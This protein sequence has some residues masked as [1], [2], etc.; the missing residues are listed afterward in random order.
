MKRRDFLQ[1]FSAAALLSTIPGCEFNAEERNE[2][3]G[4]ILG[5]N[6]QHGHLLRQAISQAVDS[7]IHQEVIIVGGGVSGLTA[8]HHLKKAGY[9]EFSLL[10]FHNEAGGNA[11][12]GKNATSTFPWGAHYLPIP[13]T[14]QPELIQFLEETGVITHWEDQLPYFNDDY[15]CFE[16]EE[17]LFIK[18][19]WQDGLIPDF[20]L[21]VNDRKEIQRFL[22]LMARF[23]ESVGTDGKPLFTIP[24][25]NSS[26]DST[27]DK[28]N[29]QSFAEYLK[30]NDFHSPYLNWYLNYC[31]R[32][33]YG[34]TL[35]ETSAWA[36]IHYFASRK[37]KAINAADDDVL[38]WPE[39]NFWLTNQL[40]KTFDEHIKTDQLVFQ[41]K[42]AEQGVSL[43]AMDIHTKKVNEYRCKKA[44]IC[45]PQF[46]NKHIIREFPY[47]DLD[48]V[49]DYAPWMV[50]NITIKDFPQQ[51]GQTLSWDNVIYQG[52]SLGYVNA[53]HQMVTQHLER[54]VLTF[55]Q[56][57]TKQDAK[58]ERTAALEKDHSAWVKHILNELEPPHPGIS[59]YIENIDVWMWGHAMA[60]PKKGVI[61][62]PALKS[63]INFTDNRL[64]FAHSDLSGISI[65]EE[66]F[67]HGT[68]VAKQIL[69]TK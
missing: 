39:G 40:K 21:D 24:I 5:A 48:L 3:T 35:T 53:N 12:G 37:G 33:D 18:N 6:H 1:Y 15:L 52:Y 51:N 32:D 44:V 46:I 4:A 45:T 19:H 14:D 41:I 30:E 36:G 16:P 11:L 47:P 63:L 34:T 17:R 42:P 13:N 29:S 9:N 64:F 43:L 26:T 60:R 67:Y 55:Y 54:R 38:T 20:G 62:H 49:L 59:R 56:P 69:A 2:I 7:V 57:L 23:K 31:C 8:A 25:A 28:L 61:N 65:F 50:A 66:A 27:F 10:E 68:R 22:K 58:A